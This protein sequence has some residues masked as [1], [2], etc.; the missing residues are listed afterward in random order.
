M[1]TGTFFEAIHLQESSLILI[2][3]INGNGF[4]ALPVAT[5]EGVK[6]HQP[7]ACIAQSDGK[8]GH[9]T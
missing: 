3:L 7:N 9:S 2:F 5:P 1:S 8:F 6:I 4:S